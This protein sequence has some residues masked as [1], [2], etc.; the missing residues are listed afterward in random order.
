M[1]RETSIT[2]S[3]VAIITFASLLASWA[4]TALVR[5][6]ALD[7]AILDIPN[8]RSSHTVPTPR[9]GGA[10]ILLAFLTGLAALAILGVIGIPEFAGIGGGAALI[11]V[12]GWVD[13]RRGVPPLYRALVQGAAAIWALWWLGGLSSVSVGGTSL[14]LGMV[15]SLFAALAI[16]WC[17]NLFN[18]MDGIDGIAGGQAATGGI[19]GGA[20]LL[21]AGRLDLAAIA[22]LVAAASL[23]FL[24]WN[25]SPA[26]IFMGDVGSSM[27]GFVFATLAVAGENA[28]AVPLPVSVLLGGPFVLDATVTLTRRVFRGARWYEAHR[29]HAYQRAVQSGLSHQQVASAIII[30]NLVLGFAVYSTRGAPPQQLAVVVIGFAALGVA[31]LC[32]E[33]RLPMRDPAEPQAERSAVTGTGVSTVEQRTSRG[34]ELSGRRW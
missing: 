33:R 3:A 13:D 16:V 31:Y 28:G 12:I 8:H 24:R 2:A 29:S 22:F 1:H 14:H 4:G 27:L 18:F 17:T 23:G 32:V 25:W 6:Y 5:R 34:R 10:A 9:G 19:A 20:L 26:K 30:V 7:R 15:G 21:A 11:G